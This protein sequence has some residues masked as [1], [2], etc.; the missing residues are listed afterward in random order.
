MCNNGTAEILA[1][2][3]IL[4]PWLQDYIKSE[5]PARSLAVRSASTLGIGKT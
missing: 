3:L 1:A 5:E 4:H 2:Q